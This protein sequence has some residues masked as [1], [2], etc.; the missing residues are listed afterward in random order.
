MLAISLT[1]QASHRVLLF[2]DMA[3][4]KIVEM[5]PDFVD[6]VNGQSRGMENPGERSIII[7]AALSAHINNLLREQPSPEQFAEG[8]KILADE[9]Y[10]R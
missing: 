3:T 1:A 8:F 2:N 7:Q 5:W 4:D 6:S 10:S 9:Y